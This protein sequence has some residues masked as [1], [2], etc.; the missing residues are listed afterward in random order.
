MTNKKLMPWARKVAV[1]SALIALIATVYALGAATPQEAL[2]SS[3]VQSVP[4]GWS[5][6]PSG[7]VIG[8]KFRLIFLSSE[9]RTATPTNMTTYNNWI[10]ARAASGHAD[11]R[12]YSTAFSVVGCTAAVDARDNTRTTYTSSNK[13]VPIYWLNGN[14]VADDYEDFY[15]GSWDDEVNDKNQHGNDGPDTSQEANYPWTGCKH[16]GTEAFLGS[17]S[18]SLGNTVE[19]RGGRPNS[20]TSGNGP[21]SSNWSQAH[22]SP[23][24]MYGLSKVIEITPPSNTGTLTTGGTPR[25]GSISGSG[26]G[27]YWQVKL[28]QNGKYRID[29]KGS[30]SSQYGGT[31]TNPRIKSLRAAPSSSC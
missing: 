1:L 12:E 4:H 10:I 26:V 8:D 7:L 29:V 15:D 6:T 5:L 22:P 3:H 21:L 24:P 20:T 11:I 27:E 31:I 14:K 23:H 30:E 19:T 2:A 9:K 16:N 17:D 13:G 28:H 18:E 25:T